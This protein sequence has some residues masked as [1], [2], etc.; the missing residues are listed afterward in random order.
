MGQQ[1]RL[2]Q[3]IATLTDAETGRIA[4]DARKFTGGESAKVLNEELKKLRFVASKQ[5]KQIKEA[6]SFH[7]DLFRQVLTLTDQVWA[8]A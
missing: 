6:A 5:Q 1:Q 4:N 7:E 2:V 8:T 3:Q